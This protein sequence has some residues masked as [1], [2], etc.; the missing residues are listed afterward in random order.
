LD[1]DKEQYCRSLR[2]HFCPAPSTWLSSIFSHAS[3]LQEAVSG[4]IKEKIYPSKDAIVARQS[5]PGS[6]HSYY[7][8]LPKGLEPGHTTWT[9][10]DFGCGAEETVFA[11]DVGK[12]FCDN[13]SVVGSSFNPS[14]AIRWEQTHSRSGHDASAN[15]SGRW[16]NRYRSTCRR[17]ALADTSSMVF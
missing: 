11:G 15:G 3:S 5:G 6:Y 10:F 12:P 1:Q 2:M 16:F 13:P 4:T 17:C 8:Q 7:R 14:T 9:R